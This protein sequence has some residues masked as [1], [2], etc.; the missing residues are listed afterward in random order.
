MDFIHYDL[1]KITLIELEKLI[2]HHNQVYWEQGTQEISDTDYDLLMRRLKE[3]APDHPLLE[4]VGAPTVSA[5]GKVEYSKP[6]LSLDKA[7]SLEEVIE[8][9]NK[10]ARSEI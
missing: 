4:K 2:E 1:Q 9:A 5:I 6:M 8:W 7:Y 10:H 3:I